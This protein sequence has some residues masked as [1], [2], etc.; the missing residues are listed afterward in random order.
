MAQDDSGHFRTVQE[1]I[2]AVPGFRKK[3][4]TILIK[5]GTYKE[6]YILAGTKT[7]EP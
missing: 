4:T 2:N 5:K 3:V 1:A 7:F 6:K